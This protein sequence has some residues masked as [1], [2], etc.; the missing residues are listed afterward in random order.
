MIKKRQDEENGWNVI[1]EKDFYLLLKKK[2]LDNSNFM[3]ISIIDSNGNLIW[4]RSFNES[5]KDKGIETYRNYIFLDYER[6]IYPFSSDYKVINLREYKHLRTFTSEE[7]SYKG[8]RKGE[9]NIKYF[10][11]QNPIVTEK[12][13]QFHYNE[14]LVTYG[15]KDEIT[16]I[17][18]EKFDTVASY[19]YAFDKYTYKLLYHTKN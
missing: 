19:R 4:E 8:D 16:G 11:N 1:E 10:M 17:T 3:E 2:S 6:I 15:Y 13:I 5:E 9:E 12:E 14:V 18:P 7:L